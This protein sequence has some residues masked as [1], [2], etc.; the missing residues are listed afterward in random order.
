LRA[1]RRLRLGRGFGDGRD[2]ALRFRAAACAVRLPSR[3]LPAATRHDIVWP[4][5]KLAVRDAVPLR[6]LARR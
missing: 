3:A 5:L 4:G 2:L 1:A 6:H